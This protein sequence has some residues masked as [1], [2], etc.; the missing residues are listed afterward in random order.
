MVN[1][2]RTRPQRT[3]RC[4]AAIILTILIVSSGRADI[5]TMTDVAHGVTLTQ[6][7]C[8]AIP[9]AVWISARGRNLCMRYYLSIA[10]GEGLRP[11]VFL[12]G[13]L[14]FDIDPKTG[15]WLVPP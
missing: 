10:G 1:L 6:N 8:A 13:D 5:I 11:V 2:F 12:Q 9:Q 4:V 3:G 7:Q 15:A 14:G